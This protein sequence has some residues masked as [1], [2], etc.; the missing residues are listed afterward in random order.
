[1]PVRA[2]MEDDVPEICAMVRELAEF[3]EAAGE[4]ALDPEELRLH[5]FGPEPAAHVLIAHP[6]AE[7]GAVAGMAL[8]FRTYSTWVGRPGIWLEDLFIRPEYRRLGLAGELMDGLA[9]RTGGRVEWAV[10]DWNLG[11]ISFYDGLGARPVPG[12]TRYRW[13]PGSAG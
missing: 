13:L 1:M 10:L 9:S 2:A 12:W 8:W 3:E 5:L 7:P 6:T 4:V 11:A